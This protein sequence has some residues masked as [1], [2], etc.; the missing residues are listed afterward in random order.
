MTCVLV[1]LLLTMVMI[2]SVSSS[3]KTTNDVMLRNYSISTKK[4]DNYD[5][6]DYDDSDGYDT[7]YDVV[8]EE[9]QLVMQ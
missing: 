5:E 3:K 6:Y 2:V 9:V 8:E 7:G 1:L 4:N